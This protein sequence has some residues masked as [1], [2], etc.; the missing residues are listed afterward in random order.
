MTTHSLIL[1][2]HE[3]LAALDDRLGLVVRPVKPQP[4]TSLPGHEGEIWHHASAGKWASGLLL[5]SEC[6][7]GTPGDRLVG[8]ETWCRH[9]RPDTGYLKEA[10]YRADGIVFDNPE[11]GSPWKAATTMPRWASRITLEVVGVRCVRLQSLTEEDAAKTGIERRTIEGQVYFKNYRSGC[12]I[13]D[14][15]GSLRTS[16]SSHYG[17]R[18][19][20][21]SN[22]FAWAVGVK[23]VEVAA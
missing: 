9:W 17:K 21:E 16:W 7:L 18:Y 20:W 5:E 23:R 10:L 8:K 12:W 3:V 15:T 19:P 2:P 1:S 11:D 6:P 14:S 4:T 13:L 22:P